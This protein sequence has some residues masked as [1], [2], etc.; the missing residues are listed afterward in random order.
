[1]SWGA[2]YLAGLAALAF[3]VRPDLEPDD[4]EK[5]IKDTATSMPFGKVVNP[6][7]VISEARTMKKQALLSAD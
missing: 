5:L 1:L 3:Q 6:G 4:I 7:R 2:P